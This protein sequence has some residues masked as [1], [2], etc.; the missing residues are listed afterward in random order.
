MS[1]KTVFSIT[2]VLGL[3]SLIVCSGCSTVAGPGLG[4]FGVPIPISPYLQKSAEDRFW[5]YERYERMPILGPITPGTPETALDEPSDDQ[6]MRKLEK[7]RP[8]QGGLPFLEEIQRN[9]VRIVKEKIA[10]YID[11]PRVYPL[12]GPAQ[13]HHVHYKCIVYFTE[14]TRIGWP[15]PYTTRNEEAQEV[16]YIDLDHF[17]MVGNVDPGPGSN[18]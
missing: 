16:I 6:V 4:V 17:H 5:E 13:L 7:A 3:L 18:Y 15:I 10:D 8:I 14:V 11:E 2:G 1:S 12:I 9:N